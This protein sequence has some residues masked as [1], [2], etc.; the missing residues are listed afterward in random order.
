[1]W[2]LAGLT[3]KDCGVSYEDACDLLREV[4]KSDLL[5]FEDNLYQE[6]GKKIVFSNSEVTV[7]DSICDDSTMRTLH[8]NRRPNLVQV[9]FN[10][11]EP[12]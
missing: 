3:H 7:M 6:E 10:K 8:F 2:L 12:F 5:E 11:V 1:M 9:L 4:P